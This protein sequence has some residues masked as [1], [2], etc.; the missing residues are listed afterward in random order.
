[1]T[2]TTTAA[3][4][5]IYGLGLGVLVHMLLALG[6]LTAFYKYFV[7]DVETRAFNSAIKRLISTMDFSSTI[8]PLTREA[9]RRNQPTFPSDT[10][11]LERNSAISTMTYTILAIVSMFTVLLCVLPRLFC[12]S[13]HV[14]LLPLFVKIFTVVGITGVVEYYFFV[15][16]IQNYVPINVNE[17]AESFKNRMT[18][19][20]ST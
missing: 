10:L 18:S 6:F 14:E 19:S 9:L 20:S 2:A 12:S 4:N 3:S 11:R 16:F 8:D 13:I 15:N 7:L 1:M 17:I 5:Y